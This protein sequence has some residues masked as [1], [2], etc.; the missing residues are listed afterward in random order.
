MADSESLLNA[1]RQ[2]GL[3]GTKLTD[4]CTELER[5]LTSPENVDVVRTREHELN[6]AFDEFK[7]AHA[8][9]MEL[10]PDSSSQAEFDTHYDTTCKNFQEVTAKLRHYYDITSDD[11]MTS[12]SPASDTDATLAR[13]ALIESRLADMR[14]K[15]M[16]AEQ[17]LQRV[18]NE[19]K[20]KSRELQRRN[21]MLQNFAVDTERAPDT[22]RSPTLVTAT[23]H[24]S[25]KPNISTTT[26]TV[27]ASAMSSAVND[28]GSTGQGIPA[29]PSRQQG[30]GVAGQ[31]FPAA[32]PRL[33]LRTDSSSDTNDGLLPAQ[34]D[35]VTTHRSVANS[36]TRNDDVLHRLASVLQ[37]GFSLPKPELFSFNGDSL[38]FTKFVNNFKL[39]IENRVHDDRVKLN[40]LI[41]YCEGEAKELIEDC[42]LLGDR[43]Y[44]RAMTLLS[45][46]YGR[47]Y[48]VAQSYVKMLTTGNPI[49]ANDV[50]S[51]M[52]LSLEMSRAE[53]T[54]SELGFTAEIDNSENLKKIVA[55]L[56]S[57]LKSKWV[58]KAYRINEQGRS[59]SFKDLSEFV[60]ERA[61]IENSMYG[62]EYAN[63][64]KQRAQNKP[65]QSRGTGNRPNFNRN[66]GTAFTTAG[67]REYPCR[68][69][70]GK[71]TRVYDCDKF[72][73][74]SLDLR[75]EF[76]KK[77]GL[78]RNCFIPKHMVRDCRKASMCEVTGCGRKHHTLLH[79]WIAVSDDQSRSRIDNSNGSAQSMNA[80]VT[81]TCGVKDKVYLRILPVIVTN[82]PRCVETYALLDNGSDVSLVDD[83]LV[84]MLGIRGKQK[85]FVINSVNS[86]STVNG[87]EVDFTV[88]SMHGDDIVNLKNAWS[89][90]KLPISLHSAPTTTDIAKWPHLS[91]IDIP[92]VNCDHVT[93][94]IGS[95]TPEAFWTMEERRGKRGE[96]YA[97]RS[98]LGWSI[99]GPAAGNP[100]NSAN[101]NLLQ[102]EV[103]AEQ[104]VITQQLKEMWNQEFNQ[105]P[106]DEKAMSQQDRKALKLMQDTIEMD[107]GHYKLA[108]PWVNDHVTMPNDRF[109]AETRL[110]YLGKKLKRDPVLQKKYVTQM[111]DYLEKDYASEANNDHVTNGR[112][113]YIPHHAVTSQKKPGKVRV[114]FDA[115]AKYRGHSLNEN[116]LQ[117]PDL[118]NSLVGV[119]MRFR[120]EPVAMVADIEAM[121]HQ[122]KVQERDRSALRFLWWEEG[123]LENPVKEYQMN[124]FIFGAKCSPSC[125]AFALRHTADEN[126]NEYDRHVIDTV[127]RDFYVDDLLKST[128]TVEEAARLSVELRKLLQRAGFNLTKW[129]SN[130]P[131]AISKIPER[132][133]APARQSIDI[134]DT[135]AAEKAL[136]VL[137]NIESD[138]FTF[139]VKSDMNA[140][141]RRSLLSTVAS[142]YDP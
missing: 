65:Q 35:D 19:L 120:Q 101:V 93:I 86:T 58:E 131:G 117:G 72:K 82:G 21:E 40:Y 60:L 134:G 47:S 80:T 133:R 94:L 104:D 64:V 107:D 70:G 112:V 92:E 24:E 122:V 103:T 126:K 85:S 98:L 139:Q 61:N 37:E 29:V 97:V 48:Q 138:Y 128:A 66:V 115:A 6:D 57:Y 34:N 130:E 137:W 62:Q 23:S 52:R 26:S 8:A 5:L 75:K 116:L 136:G 114:V 38:N 55:R 46:R 129:S 45:D 10:L 27:D 113:W 68:C 123:N 50:K 49:K 118:V 91:G 127:K 2:R 42:V 74:Q 111:N 15:Q 90:P 109:M 88:K 141:T 124:R 140:T 100:V 63:E 16:E 41:Q 125:A 39:N 99:Q 12:R 84:Q 28:T 135:P 67:G 4:V 132:E 119:L 44:E 95:D 78:C 121:F 59:V 102:R 69:C 89:V 31:G 53:I 36:N 76:V 1:K 79:E 105:P 106:C 7:H 43:G 81:S 108:L 77:N 9:C 71:C 73:S 13:Q 110:A 3:I 14:V 56:P 30:S 83:R 54:L 51:L 32:I 17:E 96:P 87:R 11:V 18:Q 22:N 20:L 142:L 25:S 33:N